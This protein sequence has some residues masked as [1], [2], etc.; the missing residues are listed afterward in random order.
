MIAQEQ[1]IK[2][3]TAHEGCDVVSDILV[4]G[5]LLKAM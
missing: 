4:D 5:G 2:R 3:R 1:A